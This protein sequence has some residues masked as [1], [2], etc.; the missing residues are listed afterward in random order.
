MDII[1]EIRRRY[2][3]Q[4]QTITAIA[5]DMGISR[6]TVR[7][8]INTVEEPKYERV[9]PLSPKLGQFEEQLT[10]W[11]SDEAKLPRPRRRSQSKT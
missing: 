2:S 6:P 11:L 3:V 5:R 10:Q 1:Y 9:Q 4:K 8:H 7:K